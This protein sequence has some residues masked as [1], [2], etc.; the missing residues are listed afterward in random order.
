MYPGPEVSG[1]CELENTTQTPKGIR[2]YY[3]QNMND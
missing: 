3:A 2:G 1:K